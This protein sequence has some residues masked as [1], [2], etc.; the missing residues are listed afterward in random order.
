MD[1]LKAALEHYDDGRSKGFFCIAAALLSTESL[2]ESLILAANGEPLKVA[3]SHFAQIEGQ[4]LKLR[5]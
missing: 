1:F 5:K 2:N 3:L 4:E